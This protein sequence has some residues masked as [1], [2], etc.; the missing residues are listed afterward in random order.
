M[1]GPAEHL[2]LHRARLEAMYP[3]SA[4]T[5]GQALNITCYSYAGSLTFGFAGDRDSVPS[6]QRIA[7]YS[8]EALAELEET[9]LPKLEKKGE[10][11]GI[12]RNKAPSRKAPKRV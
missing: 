1:P 12:T 9:F 4:T 5:H 8:G 3:V 11:V 2:Y 10:V 6:L 7:V